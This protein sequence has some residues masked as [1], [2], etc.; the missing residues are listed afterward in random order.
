MTSVTL[1]GFL[2]LSDHRL[3]FFFVCPAAFVFVLCSDSLVV[4][5]VLSRRSLHRPMYVFIAAV[6]LNSLVASMTVYPKLRSDLSGGGAVQV[7]RWACLCQ[8]F[9]F[10][11][12]GGS[13][14]MLLAAMALD[15]YLSICR[16][17]RYA[18]L[19][20]PSSVSVLL[21]L[22]WPLRAAGQPP[23]AP[24]LSAQQ[25]LLRHLQ[26]HQSELSVRTAGGRG[27]RLLAGRL[28]A[29]LVRQDPHRVL[30]SCRAFSSK[31][32]HTCLPHLIVCLTTL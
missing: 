28:R 16:P 27:H 24:L 13:S 19:V 3:L 17:P 22:C 26:L 10:Y 5:L 31:A 25:D 18:A 23:A 30:R 15:R 4:C 14:F 29:L 21:L 12:L 11:S 6:L 2:Q 8:A 1:D 7:P 20:S 32:L 9:S